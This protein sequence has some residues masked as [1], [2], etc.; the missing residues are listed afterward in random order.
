MSKPSEVLTLTGRDYLLHLKDVWQPG[1]HW[2]LVAPTGE[3][4]TNHSLQLARLRRFVLIFDLKG[5]DKTIA[6]S[7]WPRITSWPPSREDRRKMEEGQAYRRIVGSTG[8]SRAARAERVELFKKVIEAVMS[9]GGWTIIVPDLKV[10]TDARF[11]GL[12]DDVVELLILARDAGVS[13]ITDWQRPAGVPREAGDQASWLGVAYTRDEDVV[14][15]LGEMMGRSRAEL[16]GAV[17]GLGDLPYGWLVVSRRPR[18]PIILTRPE[19]LILPSPAET[20][21]ARHY[22]PG[23]W[24]SVNRWVW[25]EAA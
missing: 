9:E 23:L 12:A 2:A 18:E 15:R 25:G 6:K 11:G 20:E 17:S 24:A 7:G 14:G 13:V 10:L 5:G 3:G 19:E 16:R 1:E 22:D 8:R 21:K 4:K